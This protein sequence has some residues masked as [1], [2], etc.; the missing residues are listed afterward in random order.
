MP[1]TESVAASIHTPQDIAPLV[2]YLVS[3]DAANINGRTFALRRKGM[4]E[5][6]SDPIPVVG[7]YKEGTWTL[8]ELSRVVPM[9]L[10]EGLVKAPSAWDAIKPTPAVDT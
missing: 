8:T 6:Y 1:D 2:V 4:L 5:L 3:D 10:T 9:I 7:S